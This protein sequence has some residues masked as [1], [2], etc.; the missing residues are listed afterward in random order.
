ML[1]FGKIICIYTIENVLLKKEREFMARI[2]AHVFVDI[3]TKGVDEFQVILANEIRNSDKPLSQDEINMLNKV[4]HAFDYNY[5][6]RSNFME[7]EMNRRVDDELLD[8]C[9]KHKLLPL[10]Y[11]TQYLREWK[12]LLTSPGMNQDHLIALGFQMAYKLCFGNNVSSRKK[13]SKPDFFTHTCIDCRKRGDLHDTKTL[14]NI[15]II[16]R[17]FMPV[18]KTSANILQRLFAA[19]YFSY[20]K[21]PIK[22]VLTTCYKKKDSIE[23][24]NVWERALASEVSSDMFDPSLQRILQSSQDYFLNSTDKNIMDLDR[25]LKATIDPNDV[26]NYDNFKADVQRHMQDDLVWIDLLSSFLA[27]KQEIDACIASVDHQ[28]PN[29]IIGI[30]LCAMERVLTLDDFYSGIDGFAYV[31]PHCKKSEPIAEWNVASLRHYEQ[32]IAHHIAISPFT[33]WMANTIDNLKD[34][35]HVEVRVSGNLNGEQTFVN[36]LRSTAGPGAFSSLFIGGSEEI[37]PGFT[38]NVSYDSQKRR[39][40]EY[41]E[42]PWAQHPMFVS[43]SLELGRKNQF[44]GGVHGFADLEHFQGLGPRE[45]GLYYPGLLGV[46]FQFND[47]GRLEQ[48]LGVDPRVNG[49][50]RLRRTDGPEPRELRRL[51]D[52]ERGAYHASLGPRDWEL[53]RLTDSERRAYHTSLESRDRELRRLT[54]SERKAY[55]ASFKH[56]DRH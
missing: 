37:V 53:R 43:E 23:G 19:K 25:Q 31:C 18:H 54:D 14:C 48:D 5:G 17:D 8:I 20:V 21:N 10:F 44:E 47:L 52:S 32:R 13:Y 34:N 36:A 6:L 56:G 2:G 41:I 28:N 7:P 9:V 15:S 35:P 26:L 50:E 55:R 24:L 38:A 42:R 11:E 16:T 4:K 33:T 3:Y 22:K 39:R 49:W 46:P 51:T 45:E 27:I 29:E 40:L 30:A 1:T 12:D